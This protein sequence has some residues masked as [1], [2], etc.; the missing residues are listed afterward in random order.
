VEPREDG[1][2]L[3]HRHSVAGHLGAVGG[4]LSTPARPVVGRMI[5]KMNL[6]V[7]V[8]PAPLAPD[9]ST[10]SPCSTREGTPVRRYQ[11]PG[12]AGVTVDQLLHHHRR[13]G[14]SEYLRKV[15]RSKPAWP[16]ASGDG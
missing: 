15:R 3:P 10:I 2:V 12:A 16:V 13:H 1:Q 7:A 14:D 6:I 4:Y 9:D 8:F 11:R 5:P